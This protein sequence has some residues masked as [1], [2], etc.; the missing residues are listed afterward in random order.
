VKTGYGFEQPPGPT[1]PVEPEPDYL[2]T[3]RLFIN[4]APSPD[5]KIQKMMRYVA[6]LFNEGAVVLK[7][8]RSHFNYSFFH[9]FSVSPMIYPKKLV[10]PIFHELLQDATSNC[11]IH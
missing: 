8:L 5:S 10:F 11:G 3:V 4:P 7:H 9:V 1:F 2:P 6:K